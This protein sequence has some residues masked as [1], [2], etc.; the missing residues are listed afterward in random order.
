MRKMYKRIINDEFTVLKELENELEVIKD[1]S[2]K[3][4]VLDEI[5]IRGKNILEY[6]EKLLGSF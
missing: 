5:V 4:V 3:Q 1:D 2:L 6:Q